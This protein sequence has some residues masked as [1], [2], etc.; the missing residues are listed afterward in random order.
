MNPS[1]KAAQESAPWKCVGCGFAQCQGWTVASM[2]CIAQICET[3]CCEACQ[4]VTESHSLLWEFYC[5]QPKVILFSGFRAMSKHGLLCTA[6]PFLAD[7]SLCI[8]L[9]SGALPP[10]GQGLPRAALWASVLPTQSSFSLR[11]SP[12]VGSASGLRLPLDSYFLFICIFTSESFVLHVS[13]WFLF[14]KGPK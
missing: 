11:F 4:Q 13:F 6:R 9:C 10:P 8:G 3:M 2:R 5:F 7:G 14:S 1:R 12:G